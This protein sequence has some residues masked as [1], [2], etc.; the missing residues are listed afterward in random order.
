MDTFD[1]TSALSGD[2]MGP[3]PVDF[4]GS[5]IKFC[6]A[7]FRAAMTTPGRRGTSIIPHRHPRFGDAFYLEFRAIDEPF[8]GTFKGPPDIPIVV[9]TEQAIKYCPWC[10][11][12][13]EKFYRKSFDQLPF[14]LEDDSEY[15]RSIAQQH[16]SS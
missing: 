4:S 14:I 1:A 3:R 16:D 12:K 6:C 2:W 7:L 11:T 13:L 15:E 9:T 8:E 10:G 5:S